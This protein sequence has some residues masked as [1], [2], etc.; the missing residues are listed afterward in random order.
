MHVEAPAGA[1]VRGGL[2]GDQHR[3]HVPGAEH[4]LGHLDV[5]AAEEVGHRAHGVAGAEAAHHPVAGAVEPH[6][7][8]VP[9]EAHGDVPAA[10]GEVPDAGLLGTQ[11][12]GQGGQGQKRA[13]NEAGGRDLH[14]TMRSRSLDQRPPAFTSVPLET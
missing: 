14:G 4:L 9:Q 11:G 1:Q 2:G 8:P 10:H 5:E 7:Q 6:H 12:A 13:G 3:G